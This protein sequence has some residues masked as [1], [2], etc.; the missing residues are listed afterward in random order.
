MRL[1]VSKPALVT[2]LISVALVGLT[3]ACYAKE[4]AWL[5][6]VLQPLSDELKDAMDIDHDVQGV[7]VSD[8][9]AES[10]ADASGLED[11]DVI[12]AIGDDEIESVTE[13]VDAIKA[14]EPGDD[15]DVV[16]LRDGNKRKVIQVE[17]GERGKDKIMDLGLDFIPEITKGF[18][19]IGGSQ[20]FLGVEIH[21]MSADLADYFDVDEGEGVLVLG[22]NE[23]SPA[24]EAGLRAGD[25][26]L[27]VEGKEVGDTDHLVKYVRQGDPGDRVELKIK[28]KHRTETV[29]VTL[30][31][32]DS[33]SRVFVQE[34][35]NPQGHKR[36]M[37]SGDDEM[38]NLDDV[39]IYKMH[40][41]DF[42]KQL[43]ELRQELKQLKEEIEELR[44]S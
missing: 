33:P 30:G 14:F 7:L 42:E 26:I 12:V 17:L 22:V 4:D 44:K 9:V 31:E 18:K 38:P 35:K 34:I 10:P 23:G 15:V 2:I 1:G 36:I 24:E 11:G 19:W 3:G 6:V 39:K 20:G 28:R 40:K 8:V 29:Q 5:G 43:Q 37:I 41:E 16:V 13:A 25:V 21:D 32:T 27:E